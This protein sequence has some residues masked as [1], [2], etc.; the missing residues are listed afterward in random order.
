MVREF[1]DAMRRLDRRLVGLASHRQRI[2]AKPCDSERHFGLV[3]RV[4]GII[5]TRISA[6]LNRLVN[7]PRPAE[8]V[9]KRLDC[10]T[11]GLSRWLNRIITNYSRGV[12]KPK[13]ADQGKKFGITVA[14]VNPFYTSP[15]YGPCGFVD[16]GNRRS[17]LAFNC[18]HCRQLAH[19]EVNGTKVVVAT[20]CRGLDFRF[21]SRLQPLL[22]R[23]SG[24]VKDGRRSTG[25]SSDRPARE[26]RRGNEASIGP[27]SRSYECQ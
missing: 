17:Q 2:G 15:D 20:R 9:V 8:I 25:A 18:L 27:C 26:K 23:A 16:R 1:L 6:A 7:V 10:R 4:R 5:R 21:A 11:R 24:S 22:C 13:L 3:D 19:P 12:F 14:E